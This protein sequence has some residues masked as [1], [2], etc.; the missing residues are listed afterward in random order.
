MPVKE[1]GLSQADA[2]T[3]TADPFITSVEQVSPRV[4]PGHRKAASFQGICATLLAAE[5]P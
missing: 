3:R 1:L 4:A 5:D 2:R